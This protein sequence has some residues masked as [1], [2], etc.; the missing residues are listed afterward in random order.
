MPPASLANAEL[1]IMNLLWEQ[2]RLTARAIREQ[3]Y[4]NAGRS[5]HGTVQRLLQRLEE[6]G[7]VRRDRTLSVHLFEAVL[8]QREYA[9]SQLELLTARLS[10]GSL[11]PLLTHLIDNRKLTSAEI[12]RL[13][14]ILDKSDGADA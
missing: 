12:A 11:A 1:S 4:P 6:K 3:L 14:R 9:S 13:R 7:F 5:Q 2:R 10:G 8:T